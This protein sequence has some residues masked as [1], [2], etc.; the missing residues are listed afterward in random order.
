MSLDHGF[1]LA[2]VGCSARL[3]VLGLEG[4][5]RVHGAPRFDATV[6][7]EGE[8][9]LDPEVLLG[10]KATLT[11]AHETDP[12]VIAGVVEAVEETATGHRLTLGSRVTV[13]EDFENTRVF[14]DEDAAGI[15]EKLLTDH[16]VSV[17]NR[18]SRALPKRAQCVQAFESDLRFIGRILAEEGILWHLEQQG[19]DEVVVLSDGTAA[20]RP[21]VGAETIPFSDGEAAGLWGEEAV[22]EATLTRAAAHDKVTLGDHDFER[23]LVDQTVSEG[24]GPLE[25]HEHPGGYTDPGLGSVLAKIRLEEMQARATVLRGRTTSRR[26]SPGATFQLSGAPRRE[27]NGTW[28]VIELHHHG[29]DEGAAATEDGH[30]YEARFVAVPTNT[31]HRPA[32]AARPTFGGVQTA[33]TT[34]PAGAEIHTERH[35]RVK[36]LLRWDRRGQKD[37]RSS[38]W[39]RPLQPPMSGGFFLP[40]TGWEVLVGF[41]GTSGDTPY[42]LGRLTNAEAP[43][44]E[45]LPSEKARS[46]FGTLTTPGGG[47]ANQ[48][49][50]DDAA[51]AEGM[52]INASSN[53]NERTENDKGTSVK[54][55]DVH[56]VGANHKQIVGIAH[57][58]AVKGAQTY[59]IAGSRDVTTVGDLSISTGT[60]SVTVGGLR[61]FQVGGDYTS[62]AATVSRAVGA[63][64][65]EVAIQEVNRHVSGVSTVVVGGSWDEIGGLTSSVSVLGASALTVGGPLSYKAKHYSLKASALSETYGARS[66]KAGAKRVEVFGGPAKYAVG[67][68]MKLKGA[69]VNFKADAQI[70]LKASGATI[71]IT[72]AAITIR[73]TFD[74]SEASIVTGTDVTE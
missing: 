23:P 69:T 62:M 36:A 74:S 28:L 22:F 57:V 34:G 59:S 11:L 39:I 20:Y 37:D 35:G 73:G 68:A 9:A 63:L 40:R 16:G 61:S 1:E 45:A 32:R 7:A 38:A 53:Y 66:V 65:A 8:A 70:V 25:R 44:A 55:D 43:P 46:N 12:R 67:A 15:A 10:Q 13:L 33:T 71:T 48:L 3:R 21:I 60:E 72:P 47:S 18:L 52:N 50:L 42:E 17:E 41:A 27:M 19:G 6:R 51:G 54:G 56:A 58:L 30:R 64:K 29:A 4:A 14:V 31:A 49:C 2:I 26:L 24:T 5:E